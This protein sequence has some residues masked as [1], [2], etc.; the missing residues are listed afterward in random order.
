[1]ADSPSTSA[2]PPAT[3]PPV[4][5]AE[6]SASGG[7][8]L[9]GG[10]YDVLRQLLLGLNR[11]LLTRLAALLCC[12]ISRSGFLPGGRSI[13]LGYALS[14]ARR[15]RRRITARLPTAAADFSNGSEPRSSAAVRGARLE[16]GRSS[17]RDHR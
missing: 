12:S 9:S 7:E 17:R 1:M 2:T 8:R 14:D 13:R 6:A 15:D 3:T 16:T 10:A 5:A 11:E 4:A